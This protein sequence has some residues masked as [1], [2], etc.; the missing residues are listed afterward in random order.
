MQEAVSPQPPRATRIFWAS[1][2]A[3]AA[4]AVLPVACTNDD[5]LPSPTASPPVT[6]TPA[7]TVAAAPTTPAP[8]P[9]AP[10]RLNTTLR[11]IDTVTGESHM[12]L[13]SAE[14]LPG[15]IDAE[16]EGETVR[17]RVF[18]SSPPEEFTFDFGGIELS[19][20]PWEHRGRCLWI[21]EDASEIDGVPYDVNCGHFSPDGSKMPYTVTTGT[22]EV[23]AG[24]VVVV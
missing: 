4:F 5:T 18:A 13:D 6:A 20:Q 14:L 10:R 19:R 8:T 2:L 24:Y 22:T 15:H 23:S 11:L 12:L 21:D 17:V 1:V 7:P 9:V 16:F 3:F